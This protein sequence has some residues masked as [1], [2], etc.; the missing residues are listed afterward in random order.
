MQAAEAE[1]TQEM[2]TQK[3]IVI[4]D[5]LEPSQMQPE[6]TI[7]TRKEPGFD[8]DPPDKLV[9]ITGARREPITQVVQLCCTWQDSDIKTFESIERIK[10]NSHA[11]AVRAVDFLESIAIFEESQPRPAKRKRHQ[12]P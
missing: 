5:S 10:M 11:D 2:Q 7:K 1:K 4:D 6:H 12:R 8:A 3:E 9:A